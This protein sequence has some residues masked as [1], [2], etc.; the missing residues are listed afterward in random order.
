MEI[1][2]K[3]R[4][5]KRKF[6]IQNIIYGIDNI[7]KIRFFLYPTNWFFALIFSSVSIKLQSLTHNQF[8]APRFKSFIQYSWFKCGYSDAR[9]PFI[10]PV[11]Y[12][13]AQNTEKLCDLQ[14]CY[15]PFLH[16]MC[17]LWTFSLFSRTFLLHSIIA[18]VRRFLVSFHKMFFFTYQYKL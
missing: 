12:C 9:L 5:T 7:R 17:P 3:V 16:Q 2:K 1:N 14:N 4:K 11:E 8:S 10:H 18:Q 13:F 6:T 15:L